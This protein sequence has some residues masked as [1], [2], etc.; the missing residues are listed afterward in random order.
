M[1]ETPKILDSEAV[2]RLRQ[3]LIDAKS[4]LD[5]CRNGNFDNI[6]LLSTFVADLSIIKMS[7]LSAEERAVEESLDRELGT[8]GEEM[9]RF[10]DQQIEFFEKQNRIADGT[11][12]G[13][14]DL[15]KP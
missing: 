2:Q 9:M 12:S 5:E 1:S 3:R 6:H 7:K 11:K 8:S 10:V 13:I 15:L 4:A 14:Q